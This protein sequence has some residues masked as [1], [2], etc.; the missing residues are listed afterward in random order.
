MSFMTKRTFTPEFKAEVC[1]LVLSEK[2]TVAEVA[3]EHDLHTSQVYS[4][5]KKA[6][7]DGVSA[8]AT[9]TSEELEELRRLRKEV[10]E[11]REERDFLA[12]AARY[13]AKAKK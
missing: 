4:W 2:K 8:P 13:F 6:R 9:A 11:L 10:R 1:Q 12:D 5:L 7:E 3:D